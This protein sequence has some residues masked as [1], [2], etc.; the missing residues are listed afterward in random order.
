[1]A[2]TILGS[3]Q[4][5][6]KNW[7][8]SILVGILYIFSGIWVMRTPLESYVS[9]SIIFSVFIFVSGIFQIVFSISSRN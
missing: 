9:L 4:A 8:I 1:M 6:V 3:A 2:I 7:W 5:A